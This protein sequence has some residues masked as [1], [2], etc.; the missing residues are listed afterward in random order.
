MSANNRWVRIKTGGTPMTGTPIAAATAIVT[1]LAILVYFWTLMAVGAMRG[2]HKVNAPTMTGPLEFECAVRVQ[3]NTLEQLP[4]FLPLLW[5]AT[6]YFSPAF[7]IAYLPWLPPVL[8]VVWIIGRILYKTGYMAAPEKRGTG[9]M[10]AG[11]AL[12]GL[13]ICA[14]VGIVMQLSATTG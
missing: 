13:L 3:T 4:V 7:S 1:I 2:K 11:I 12:I 9:F 6:I 14:L 8:G 5:L 10:I